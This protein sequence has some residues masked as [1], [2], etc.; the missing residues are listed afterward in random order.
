MYLSQVLCELSALA[1]KNEIKAPILGFTSVQKYEH[2]NACVYVFKNEKTLV[3]A[4]RGS[5]DIHDWFSNVHITPVD[6]ARGTI[7]SGFYS[8]YQKLSPLFESDLI[9]AGSRTVF[10]TGHSLGGALAVI[11]ACFFLHIKPVVVTFGSPRVGTKGFNDNL[12]SLIYIR[13][14]NGNDKVCK[15]P[16]RKYSHCG[17]KRRLEFVWYRRFTQKSPHHIYNYL[18][19]IRS[20]DV[21]NFEH[22][23]LLKFEI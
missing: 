9:N 15:L 23:D 1:Y 18:K 10:L 21:K 3:L 14:V 7:H 5:N 20:A 2:D 11:T 8:E 6:T 19:S 12:S 13:W 22:E 4:F 16:V 17:T